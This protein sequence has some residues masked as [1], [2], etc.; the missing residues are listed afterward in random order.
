M[1]KISIIG[2]PIGNLKDITLRA[3]E[4]LKNVDL[5]AC[6]D[7]RVTAKLLNHIEI[8]KKMVSLN[9]FNETKISHQLIDE[10]ISKDLNLGLVS[11]AGMPLISDPGFTLI[12]L[13]KEK[14]IQIELIPG[15][16]AAISAFVLSALSNQFVFMGFPKEKNNQRLEQ[17]KS[18]TSNFAYIFYV[19]PHKLLNLIDDFETVYGEEIQIFLVKELTKLYEKSFEGTP[20]EIKAMLEQNSL[21]GEFTLV[22]KIKEQKRIKINK[23]PKE[24]AD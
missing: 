9:K 10:I 15:V 16:N 18:L 21:K 2:T 13:A 19:A 5:L 8:N 11:D 14:N 22:A 1:A 17:I 12:K 6:E 7:T 23:Y 4:T 20:Q 3:I 24:K